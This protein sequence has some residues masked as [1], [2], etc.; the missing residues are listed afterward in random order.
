MQVVRNLERRGSAPFMALVFSSTNRQS[1]ELTEITR[2]VIADGKLGLGEPVSMALME[3]LL[4]D[5][6]TSQQSLTS[7]KK[8]QLIPANVLLDTAEQVVWYQPSRAAV[9]WL[10]VGGERRG[11]NIIWPAL[12]FSVQKSPIKLS[13]VALDNDERPVEQSLVYDVPM[14]NCYHGG[15]FCLGSATPPSVV[16]FGNLHEF[17]QCLYGAVKTHSNNRQAIADGTSPSD[18]WLTAERQRTNKAPSISAQ[19][20][21]CLGSLGSWLF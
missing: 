20:M 14:P 13:I 18:F 7:K 9:V 2:H 4:V 6:T 5:L 3:G 10:Q 19:Q 21:T 1:S 15:G 11:V 17:E 12:L 8:Q 16:N